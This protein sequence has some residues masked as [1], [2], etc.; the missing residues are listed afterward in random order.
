MKKVITI[1][2]DDKY[3]KITK[4]S[5][6]IQIVKHVAY[7]KGCRIIRLGVMDVVPK[8]GYR[9]KRRKKKCD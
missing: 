6:N 7:S 3:N 9:E 2:I 8:I 1:L 5:M 4:H